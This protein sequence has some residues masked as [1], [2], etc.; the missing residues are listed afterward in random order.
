MDV[1]SR[2]DELRA[3]IQA[4]PWQKREA[5]NEAVSEGRAVDDEN[6]APL[7]AE[8]AA[9]RQREMLRIYFRVLAPI[10]IVVLALMLWLLVSNDPE[11]SVGGAV[12]AGITGVGMTALIIW[13]VGWRPL[14]RAEKANLALTGVGDPP[15]R[16][17][18]SHWV[19]AWL[20][21]W[22]IALV[23]GVLLRAVGV[24]LLAGPVGII[25]W[26]GLVWAVKRALDSREP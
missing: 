11:G 25:V 26:F 9:E 10:L 5:L 17:E 14:V 1:V 6:L 24:T 22:P 4:L 19:I 3:E 23:V 8:W 12:F 15:R 7:A 16:R 13:A 20:V 21:A 18:P 2:R